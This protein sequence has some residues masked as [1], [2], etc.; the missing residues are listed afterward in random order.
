MAD[1][2]GRRV[3]ILLGL[4]GTA[5][6]LLLFAGLFTVEKGELDASVVFLVLLAARAIYGVLGGGV[7]PA[8]M[9]YMADVTAHADR[10]AGAAAV[11]AAVG[12]GS[13]VGPALAAALIGGGFAVPVLGAGILTLATALVVLAVPRDAPR[14]EPRAPPPTAAKRA[15]VRGKLGFYLVLAFA[16]H[17][18]FAA[19]QTTNAFYVQDSLGVD[20]IAAVRRAA[21]ISMA[22]AACSF[23]V[24]AG[25]VRALKWSPDALLWVGLAVCFLASVACLMAPGFGWLLAAFGLL[26]AGFALA[27][28]GLVAAASVRAGADRQGQL[29]GRLQAAMAAGWIVGPLAGSALYEF[30]I[31]GP[32]ILTAGVLAGGVLGLAVG[33][34]IVQ[35][36]G[37]APH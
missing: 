17:F 6:S 3:V 15:G 32:L 36:A 31:Q 33:K 27:Q 11:G 23:A 10:A 22:F 7:Q 4:A 2:R 16:I 20:T 26:G 8:A 19:L 12:L 9:G 35:H 24:Q 37:Q 5:V 13:M 30:S 18:A 25:V 34:D 1:R 28:S 29:A 21:A 14:S